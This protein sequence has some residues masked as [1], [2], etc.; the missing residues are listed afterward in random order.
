MHGS[1]KA[2]QK[3]V[4]ADV[5]YF[6]HRNNNCAHKFVCKLLMMETGVACK[7]LSHIILTNSIRLKY[8]PCMKLHDM[9]SFISI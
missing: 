8:Q 9:N 4:Y 2:C 7:E 1:E 5:W 6:Y 3:K